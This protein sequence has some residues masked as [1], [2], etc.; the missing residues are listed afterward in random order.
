MT[1][2][3]EWYDIKM[4]SLVEEFMDKYDEELRGQMMEKILDDP[5]Q[6]FHFLLKNTD[7]EMQM[8]HYPAFWRFVLARWAEE[9]EAAIDL[10]RKDRLD[11]D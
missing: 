3:E 6:D 10:F 8:V 9:L 5:E 4:H 7:G 1:E 11:E 2:L